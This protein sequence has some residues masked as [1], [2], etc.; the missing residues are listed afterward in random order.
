MCNEELL[1]A[2]YVV[3]TLVPLEV[4]MQIIKVGRY[5]KRLILKDMKCTDIR[6]GDDSSV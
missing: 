6:V 3:C 5:A 4:D 2:N 1:V